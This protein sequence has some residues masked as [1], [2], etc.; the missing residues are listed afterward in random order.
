[1]LLFGVE[2]VPIRRYNKAVNI[3]RAIWRDGWCVGTEMQKKKPALFKKI[4]AITR[5]K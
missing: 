1:M 5:R 2:Y 3:V 4:K